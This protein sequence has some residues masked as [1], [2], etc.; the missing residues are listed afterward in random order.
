[1]QQGCIISQRLYIEVNVVIVVCLRKSARSARDIGVS[2]CR[3]IE[4]SCVFILP[5]M[6]QITQTNAAE[7]HYFAEKDSLVNVVLWFVCDNLRDLRDTLGF[8][9]CGLIEYSYVYSPADSADHAE[10][11]QQAASYRR[12]RQ[13]GMVK[14]VLL[15][16]VCLRKSARSA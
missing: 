10:R 11:M 1:M 3:L 6:A 7:L 4:Y 16:G 2:L 12:E 9:L 15:F 13:V 5:Q 14:A 8:L